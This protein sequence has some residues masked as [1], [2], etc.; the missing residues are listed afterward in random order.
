MV[1]EQDDGKEKA[2][3]IR[4]VEHLLVVEQMVPICPRTIQR[5]QFR[6]SRQLLEQNKV[7]G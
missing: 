6:M 4:A 5:F 1:E 7:G 3:R 2:W